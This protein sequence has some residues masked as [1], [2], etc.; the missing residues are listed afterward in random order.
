MVR[1]DVSE[2]RA[3]KINQL[4][5]GVHP[6]FGQIAPSAIRSR[7]AGRGR[8]GAGQPHAARCRASDVITSYSIHYT[9]LYD[10]VAGVDWILADNWW[11]YQ[12]PSFVTPPFAGFVSGHSTFSRAAA[13]V[14]ELL[15]G[16]A[17]FP[18]GLGEFHAPR[19]EFLVSYN[20]V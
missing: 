9:K 13:V 15:T 16:D 12:R 18:G 17:F 6:V 2:Q 20:F 7:A 4:A 8:A 19:N 14:M 1:W 5:P 11:P 3:R 10:D